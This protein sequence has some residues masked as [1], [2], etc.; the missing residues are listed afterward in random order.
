MRSPNRHAGNSERHRRLAQLQHRA[1]AFH[2]S[3][4]AHRRRQDEWLDFPLCLGR[5]LSRCVAGET[6]RA[7]RIPARPLYSP[8]RSARLRGHGTGSGACA[9]EIRRFG[10]AR[11]KHAAAQPDAR[12]VLFSRCYSHHSRSRTDAGDERVAAAGFVRKLPALPGRLPDAGVR[13]T[14]RHGCA[15]V[16]FLPDDRIARPHSGGV[17]R[18]DGK[19]CVR[20]RHLPGRLPVEPARADCRDTAVPAK[21]FSTTRRKPHRYFSPAARRITFPSKIRMAPW[22]YGSR[23]SRALSRKPRQ[24]HQMAW[25]DPQCLHRAREFRP[26]AGHGGSPSNQRY[27]GA[28]RGFGGSGP[29]RICPMG[30]LA[31]PITARGGL[32]RPVIQPCYLA[33]FLT[34]PVT[35]RHFTSASAVPT[36]WAE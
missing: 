23:L 5:R 32:A 27:V 22:T 17:P 8:I 20:L 10:M 19:S 12:L 24:T 29:R 6:G 34:G 14:L 18:A 36:I 35:E 1:A 3:C 25:S 4:V 28:A 26:A 7:R 9:C 13:R 21:S 30:T 15:K 33:W 11:E 2:R 31:H 16:H